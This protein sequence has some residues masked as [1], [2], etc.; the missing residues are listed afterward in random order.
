MKAKRI[1]KSLIAVVSLAAAIIAMVS[2]AGVSY[3]ATSNYSD[4][5]TDLQI[6][7]QFNE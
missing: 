5:L 1:F 4:A 6:D 2:G 3:A 7:T